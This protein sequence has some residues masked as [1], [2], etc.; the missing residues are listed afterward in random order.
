MPSR[1]WSLCLLLSCL[2][3]A[4]ASQPP[5]AY[6]R[7]ASLWGF[8]SADDWWARL[9]REVV[10]P[11]AATPLAP[12]SDLSARLGTDKVA[13]SKLEGDPAFRWVRKELRVRRLSGGA[14]RLT[15]AWSAPPSP[16]SAMLAG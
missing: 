2:A 10:L 5:L 3:F 13:L 15:I 16:S 12:P 11:L 6:L 4:G 7:N 14:A 8:L 1:F 9:Q